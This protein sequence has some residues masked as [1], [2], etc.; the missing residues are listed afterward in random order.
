MVNCCDAVVG[1]RAARTRCFHVEGEIRDK[2]PDRQLERPKG[3][4]TH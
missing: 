1:P 4:K 2:R 3:R